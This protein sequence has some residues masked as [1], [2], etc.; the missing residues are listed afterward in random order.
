MPP[1]DQLSL[2]EQAALRDQCTRFLVGHGPVTAAGLLAD[3]PADTAADRYGDGGVVAELESEVAGILG[4]PAA[5]FL[6]SGTM[7]QQSVLRVH[8]D[9]RQRRTVIFH[10]MCHLDR[11]EGQAYQRLHGL[12]G[13]PAGHP[14]RLLT[15]DDLNAIGEPPAAL[16]IELPQRDLGGQQP[17]W[18]DLRAQAEWAR[19]RGA[20]AHLD[21]ARLWESAAGYGRPLA[22]IAALFDTVYVSFY[23]GIGALPGCCVAGPADILAEVR[24]WRQRMGGTLFGLWPNA[25]SAL[26][27]LRRRLPLM[28]AYLGH[29]RA[30]AAAL[31]EVAG[32]RVIPDPPQVPMMHLLLNAT[33]DSFAAAARRL[34]AEQRVWA[35]PAAMPT[36]DPGVQRVELSVGDATR[37]LQ[38]DQVRD[39]IAALI[40]C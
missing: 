34:A 7:A 31:G 14:D 1:A 17:D 29:A 15:I 30:I 25:A 36:A 37:A 20:A 2:A 12:A 23:K 9:R 24:E 4:K 22:E 35:W 11:H 10:P 16:L 18:D 8:A 39:I 38:P 21:G 5:A 32:V 28:P 3:I 40:R 26:S 27:C 6:P 33:Q 13:R 19:G